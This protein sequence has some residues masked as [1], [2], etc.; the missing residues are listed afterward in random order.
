MKCQCACLAEPLPELV[1]FGV[2]G[3]VAHKDLGLG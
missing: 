3:D 2:V 1:L